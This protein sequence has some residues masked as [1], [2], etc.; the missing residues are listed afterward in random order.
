MGSMAATNTSSNINTLNTHHHCESLHCNTIKK[1][2]RKIL[3]N[4]ITFIQ[5][6]HSK[7]LKT[8]YELITPREHTYLLY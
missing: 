1:L 5:L 3:K 8:T 2:N 7:S 4:I 6:S